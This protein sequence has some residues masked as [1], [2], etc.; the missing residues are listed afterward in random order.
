MT[1]HVLGN[2]TLDLSYRVARLPA[3]G[4]TC[5]CS[6]RRAGPGGKGLNQAIAAARAGAAVQFH[7]AVGDDANGRLLTDR[8]R[9]EPGLT[10]RIWRR[11]GLPSDESSIWVSESGENAIV[12][13]AACAR[14]ITP[15]EAAAALDGVAPGDVVVMQ[16]N[17]SAATTATGMRAARA[18]HART[19]LNPAPLSFAPEPLLADVDVLVLNRVEAAGLG[20]ALTEAGL[21]DYAARFGGAVIVTLGGDAVLLAEPGRFRRQPVLSVRAIDTTGAGDAFVGTLAAALE[22]GTDLCAAVRQATLAGTDAVLC[23]GAL[24][25]VSV[26][27]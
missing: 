5:L 24:P 26:L 11:D 16:G 18:R 6:A 25:G 17:L 2:A 4:E 3:P 10:P 15:A 7:T 14:S 27:G 23:E 20:I 9:A 1:V 8:L 13:T 19:V 12:S 22:A 21:S